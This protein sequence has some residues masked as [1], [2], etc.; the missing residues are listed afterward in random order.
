MPDQEKLQKFEDEDTELRPSEESETPLEEKAAEDDKEDE[1]KPCVPPR[2]CVIRAAAVSMAIVCFVAVFVAGLF[3]LTARWRDP[4]PNSAPLSV[5]AHAL[6]QDMNSGRL[7]NQ[8]M[9]TPEK[10]KNQAGFKTGQT[11]TDSQ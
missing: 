10:M 2:N 8:T 6:W 5:P 4:S 3:Q 11:P 1:V 7:S 9:G